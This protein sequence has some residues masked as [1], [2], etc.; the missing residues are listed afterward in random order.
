MQHNFDRLEQDAKRKNSH[1]ILGIDPKDGNYEPYWGIIEQCHRGLAAIK[2]NLAF[3]EK[4]VET[5]MCID[6][7]IGLAQ[8][9]G[10]VTILDC[11]RGDIMETQKKY[12]QA[13]DYNFGADI[14]T[15]HGYPG[16][17]AVQPYL[18]QDPNFCAYV[19]AAM[20]PPGSELQELMTSEGIRVYQQVVLQANKW[21]GDKPELHN[22]VGF[23]VGST[24]TKAVKDIMMMCREYGIEDP[25]FLCPGFAAQGGELEFIRHAGK[26]AFFPISS[27]LIE[28]KYLKGRTPAEAIKDWNKIINKER[29]QMVTTPTM[30][31]AVVDRLLGG[32][33]NFIKLNDDPDPMKRFVL[34]KGRNKFKDATGRELSKDREHQIEEIRQA[35]KDGI[36]QDNDLTRVFFNLRDVMGLEEGDQEVVDWMA[37]LYAKEILDAEKRQGMKFQR[38]AITPMGA[39]GAGIPAV[40]A[41]KRP[42]FIIRPEAKVTHDRVVGG[43]KN[44]GASAEN[45]T[46]IAIIEDVVTTSGSVLEQLDLARELGGDNVIIEDVFA[47]VKRQ[48]EDCVGI[49][50]NAGARLHS[51]MDWDY[52]T[53]VLRNSDNPRI[54]PQLKDQLGMGK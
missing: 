8:D 17:D 25:H 47:Y 12:A 1:L 21:F 28:E 53:S 24:K 30:K 39:L 13:D 4:D 42:H 38:F 37:H 29:E 51:V 44:K 49:C 46:R 34:K 6:Q 52:F 9:C 35:F 22:R 41:L 23:V 32:G 16:P 5:R 48:E 26:N 33:E 27:G 7:L 2:I 50:A 31:E 43:I 3:G 20:S 10:L 14:Y 36:L 45:P 54:T 40:R 18:E 15:L 19:M 11:K